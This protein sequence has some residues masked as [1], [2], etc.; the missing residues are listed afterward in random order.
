MRITTRYQHNF[1]RSAVFNI[2][3]IISLS[4]ILSKN[5]SYYCY[6]SSYYCYISEYNIYIEM[7]TLMKVI[8]LIFV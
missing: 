1:F 7:M 5:V 2:L 3:I 8:I 4:A 6:I